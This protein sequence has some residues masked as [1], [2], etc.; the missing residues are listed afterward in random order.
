MIHFIFYRTI[1]NWYMRLILVSDGMVWNKVTN[2]LGA[3]TSWINSSLIL[4]HNATIGGHKISLP[5]SLPRGEYDVLF[6]NAA[7]PTIADDLQVGKR[8]SWNGKKLN[9]LPVDL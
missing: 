9:S 6:Y 3:T 4:E 1:S 2:T 5:T 8:L 7:N